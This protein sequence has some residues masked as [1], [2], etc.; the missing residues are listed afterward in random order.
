MKSFKVFYDS[1]AIQ[2]VLEMEGRELLASRCFDEDGQEV[3]DY[4][5]VANKREPKKADDESKW[6]EITLAFEGRDASIAA[7][8]SF[9]EKPSVLEM[10]YE[11]IER[12][13]RQPAPTSYP[14]AVVVT[15]WAPLTSEQAA[16]RT[17]PRSNYSP[18]F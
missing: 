4:K 11:R 14:G 1:G 2:S 5:V 16:S 12:V 7:T 6:V 9:V 17:A 18:L 13:I 15:D 8:M 3:F 10:T